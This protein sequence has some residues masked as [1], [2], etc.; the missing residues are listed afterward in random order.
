[1][2][3]RAQSSLNLGLISSASFN[4]FG[5]SLISR[6]VAEG[7]A[8]GLV[9][10]AEKSRA[11]KI[12]SYY[13]RNGLAATTRKIM[14]VKGMGG[15]RRGH[16]REQLAAYAEMHA[17]DHWDLAL[18]ALCDR[19]GI[20]YRTVASVNS[21]STVD[22]VKRAGI[23]LML[24]AG[25]EIIRAP[26]IGATTH[27]VFNTHMGKL[28][29][30]RGFNVLE[31]SLFHGDPIGVTLHLIDPGIDTGDI[32]RFQPV[33]HEP[34]DTVEALKAKCYPIDID[35]MLW[36]I[37]KVEAGELPRT[38]QA[39]DGGKQYFAM[40]PRLRR[41]IERGLQAQ[42]GNEAAALDSPALFVVPQQGP[43]G[44]RRSA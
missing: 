21:A 15:R 8:P 2:R 22:A 34:G 41:I 44:D 38:Q 9:L 43:G 13:K 37:E 3:H 29:E 16:I 4:L 14:E 20:D 33:P 32:I 42:A 31:W 28:P 6:L 1:M 5:A 39:P 24:N 11:R 30:Y 10:C 35:L 25:G 40:H 17:T 19:H 36:G 18:P 12:R 7:R 26:L 27:G 23:D